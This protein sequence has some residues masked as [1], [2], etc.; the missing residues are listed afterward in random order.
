ML[1]V[2]KL[3]LQKETSVQSDLPGL[4]ELCRHGSRVEAGKP[5]FKTSHMRVQL[6]LAE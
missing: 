1:S 3:M 4:R 2:S 6:Q 5:W